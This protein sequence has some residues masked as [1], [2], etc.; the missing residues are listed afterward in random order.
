MT[1][2]MFAGMVP[3]MVASRLPWLF[4]FMAFQTLVGIALDL[5]LTVRRLPDPFIFGYDVQ[6]IRFGIYG[7]SLLFGIPTY[8]SLYP[9]HMIYLG[10]HSSF[11]LFAAAVLVYSKSFEFHMA[12]WHLSIVIGTSIW[13]Y[14]I[15]LLLQY[16][17]SATESTSVAEVAMVT[18]AYVA[19]LWGIQCYSTRISALI[20]EPLFRMFLRPWKD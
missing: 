3:I 4:A 20:L 6:V 18:V 15:Q 14:G 7:W 11:I 16:D 1:G 13:T 19:V 5:Y 10:V 12:L 9:P 2:F 8:C 17:F